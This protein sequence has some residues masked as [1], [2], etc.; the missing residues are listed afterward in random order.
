MHSPSI[1]ICNLHG[2][3]PDSKFLMLPALPP[4]L[5][6]LNQPETIDFIGSN[7]N[8]PQI[9]PPATSPSPARKKPSAARGL[10]HTGAPFRA[11][12]HPF[13]PPSP[14]ITTSIGNP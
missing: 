3:P 10:T 11:I 12:S 4:P 5:R 13:A 2:K 14:D 8:M 1:G 6:P 9:S 7:R